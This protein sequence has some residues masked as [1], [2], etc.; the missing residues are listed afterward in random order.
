VNVDSNVVAMC[1]L[2]IVKMSL[3]KTN[4]GS[5]MK[6]QVLWVHEVLPQIWNRCLDDQTAAIR[7]VGTNHTEV[8]DHKKVVVGH[9]ET[10]VLKPTVLTRWTAI[11]LAVVDTHT[12]VREVTSRKCQNKVVVSQMTCYV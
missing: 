10:V 6:S 7:H 5:S 12:E 8:I 4:R 3:M 2:V 11:T 9:R 1:I